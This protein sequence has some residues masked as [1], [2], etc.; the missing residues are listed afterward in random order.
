MSDRCPA[1]IPLDC[2]GLERISSNLG[3]ATVC[4]WHMRI[5]GTAN[6]TGG[7]RS[8]GRPEEPDCSCP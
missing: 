4:V 3:S 1:M 6:N 7:A 2:S 8:R 5:L